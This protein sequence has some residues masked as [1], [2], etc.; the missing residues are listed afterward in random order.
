MALFAAIH[1]DHRLGLGIRALARKY[2]V[3]RRMRR[4]ALAS[5]VAG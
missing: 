1:E 3:H 2:G 4:E 5:P